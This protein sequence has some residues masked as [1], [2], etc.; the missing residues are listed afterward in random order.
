[1]GGVFC[2][3]GGAVLVGVAVLRWWG[4]RGGEEGESCIYVGGCVAGRCIGR[5]DGIVY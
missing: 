4:G 5:L 1:M 2:G 3:G